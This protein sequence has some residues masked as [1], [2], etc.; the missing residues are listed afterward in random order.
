MIMSRL[1]AAAALAACTAAIVVAEAQGAALRAG[2][3]TGD[4]SVVQTAEGPV[5]GVVS[6]DA[7]GFMGIPFAAPP[8]GNLRWAPPAAVT[9]WSQPYDA[10]KW[11]AGCPQD[12]DLPPGT[13]PPTQSEDC[14]YLNV[15]TPLPSG[16]DDGPLPV[17]LFIPGGTWWHAC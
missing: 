13:C 14:L 1:S 4:A 11:S 10:T 16:N 17:L 8:V 3:S 15:Y 9:P 12:C 7:R 2:M 6:T 5:R